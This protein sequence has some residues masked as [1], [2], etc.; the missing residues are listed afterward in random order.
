MSGMENIGSVKQKICDNYCKYPIIWD[1]EKMGYSLSDSD[2]CERCPL[3]DLR[4]QDFVDMAGRIDIMIDA[5]CE[6]GNGYREEDIKRESKI[7]YEIR[8]QL[9]EVGGWDGHEPEHKE[10][11]KRM[12][13]TFNC[14]PGVY[15]KIVPSRCEIKEE[16][17][18]AW[19]LRWI[20]VSER[21][22]EENGE[23]LVTIKWSHKS[24]VR[25]AKFAKNLRKVDKYFFADKKKQSG[26]Y[27]DAYGCDD[28]YE[29]V[30]DVIA[31]MPFP[32]TYRSEE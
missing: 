29:Y 28:G 21:L 1:E 22:P 6:L 31:W 20:P 23:Y 9:Y 30:E 17:H 10:Q 19:I 13:R 27:D 25:V 26:W 15:A 4:E 14:L 11:E 18:I 2:I 16:G 5:I 3:E 24:F 8:E 32:E 7:L 12:R